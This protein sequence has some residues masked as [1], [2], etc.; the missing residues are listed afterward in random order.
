M[1]SMLYKNDLI[2]HDRSF[3][4]ARVANLRQCR[5]C[6]A[7]GLRHSV[8]DVIAPN[9]NKDTD[10]MQLQRED[11]KLLKPAARMEQDN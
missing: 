11:L 8:T 3:R 1:P 7:S 4:G 5:A 10:G 6:H 9:H 2:S